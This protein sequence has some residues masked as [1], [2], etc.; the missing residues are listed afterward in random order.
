MR[1]HDGSLDGQ[2][3]QG[4]R[5]G[6]SLAGRLRHL[7]PAEPVAPAVAGPVEG[8]DPM[9]LREALSEARIMS[10][11]L[12]EA[13][14]SSTMTGARP[15]APASTTCSRPPRTST[16]RP[17]GGKRASTCRAMSHVATAPRART[18]ASVT[19]SARAIFMTPAG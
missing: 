1:D 9:R 8:D 19:A 10:A 15:A 6:G 11:A 18:S 13:P 5:D 16:K 17:V 7:G 3:T 12:L 2:G 4:I 14:C